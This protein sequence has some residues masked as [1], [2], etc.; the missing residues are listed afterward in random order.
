MGL[1]EAVAGTTPQSASKP[2]MLGK[3]ANKHNRLYVIAEPLGDECCKDGE[4]CK[5]DPRGDPKP[6]GRYIADTHGWDVTEASKI[7]AFGPD[8]NGPNVFMDQ[9]KGVDYLLE[10][11][12]SVNN[13]F[14]W[15]SKTGPLSDESMRGCKFMLQD[16]TLH[17][18]SIHR[19]MG[20]I[21]PTSRRAMFA[22]MLVSKPTLQEPLFLV[23]ISVPQ[24]AAGGCYEVL[25]QRRAIIVGEEQRPGTP[26]CQLK[27]HMPVNESFGFTPALRK[28]TGGKAFPQMIFSHWQNMEGDALNPG[29]MS[30]KVILIKGKPDTQSAT[31]VGNRAFPQK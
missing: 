31:R 30:G 1:A 6:R 11:K 27:A 4:D 21:M 24:D 25:A 3:S 12:E 15:A 5:I 20:Q 10:I 2:G 9:T 19:G 14:M 28:A 23:D 17:A 7:W 22:A 16:V 13:G 26:M 8:T 29:T 18:D